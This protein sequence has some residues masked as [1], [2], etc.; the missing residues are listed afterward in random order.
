LEA[1][2][3][4]ETPLSVEPGADVEA[5]LYTNGSDIGVAPEPTAPEAPS[6]LE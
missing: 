6:P 5:P 2:S 4:G 1:G 3:N